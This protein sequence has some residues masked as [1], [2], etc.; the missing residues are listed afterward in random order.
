MRDAAD[1]LLDS[2]FALGSWVRR[3]G[4]AG[5]GRDAGVGVRGGGDLL[6]AVSDPGLRAIRFSVDQVGRMGW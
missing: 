1:L 5:S 6:P 3:L 4:P 2:D